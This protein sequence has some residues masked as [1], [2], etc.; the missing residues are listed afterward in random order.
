MVRIAKEYKKAIETEYGAEV[1]RAN[2]NVQQY[3]L[4]PI[5]PYQVDPS[6]LAGGGGADASAG[7]G[8][9]QA[10]LDELRS[11]SSPANRAHFDEAFGAGAAEAALG[12]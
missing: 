6:T 4:G 5:T 2:A 7:G 9:P 11:D 12:N 1:K 3:G 10:A 8:I